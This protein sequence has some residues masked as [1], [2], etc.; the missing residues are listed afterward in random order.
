MLQDILNDALECWTHRKEITREKGA[1]ASGGGWCYKKALLESIFPESVHKVDTSSALVFEIGNDIHDKMDEVLRLYSR[2][3]GNILWIQP[4]RTFTFGKLMQDAYI[5]AGGDPKNCAIMNGVYGTPDGIII[6]V[7]NKAV[8]IPDY[9]SANERSFKFKMNGS[10]SFTHEVQVGTYLPGI[11]GMLKKLG[12]DME[13]KEAAIVYIQ[14]SDYQLCIHSYDPALAIESARSYWRDFAMHHAN[15]VSSSGTKL[16]DGN[17][18]EKWMCDYCS[19]FTGKT[20]CN[21]CTD[22][23]QFLNLSPKELLP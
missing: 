23:S 6:D 4:W 20:Q 13:V 9:K 1:H 8:L 21:S 11:T 15:F 7:E 19:V 12:I 10:R 5:T 3:T 22:L 16:P 18:P 2:E 14:K 17:P